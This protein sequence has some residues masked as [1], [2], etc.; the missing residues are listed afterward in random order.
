MNENR[1]VV[2]CFNS[3]SQ[4]CRPGVFEVAGSQRP[5]MADLVYFFWRQWTDWCRSPAGRSQS[6]S[7]STSSSTA[8]IKTSHLMCEHRMGSRV[9]GWR[10]GGATTVAETLS[11]LTSPSLVNFL[12]HRMLLS[13]NSSLFASCGLMDENH[14][15]C[16]H[17]VRWY[18]TMKQQS[19]C[20]TCS[21]VVVVKLSPQHGKPLV[22]VH[23]RQPICAWWGEELIRRSGKTTRLNTPKLNKLILEWVVQKKFF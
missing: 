19:C 12:P 6:W 18:Q 10:G 11:W 17:V 22:L 23:R 4:T 2:V 8:E 1:Q 20:V 9:G 15:Q 3:M 16:K 14:V 7:Q 21:P 5:H 13:S